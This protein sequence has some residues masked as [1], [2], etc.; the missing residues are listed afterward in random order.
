M[1]KVVTLSLKR[2]VTGWKKSSLSNRLCYSHLGLTGERKAMGGGG[3]GGQGH[4]TGNSPK[5]YRS[6]TKWGGVSQFMTGFYLPVHRTGSPQD[7]QT[8]P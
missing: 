2:S 8:Q 4:M 1:E 6:G 5:A 3:G 7:H